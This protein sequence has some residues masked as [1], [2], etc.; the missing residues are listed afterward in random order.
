MFQRPQLLIAWPGKREQ[1]YRFL[2][3]A[4]GMC[5][6]RRESEQVTSAEFM[7]L[8]E[9]AKLDSAAQHVNRTCAV[10]MVFVEMRAGAEGH[11][12]DAKVRIFEQQLRPHSRAGRFLLLQARD[13]AIEIEVL[14]DCRHVAV[15]V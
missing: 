11:Q 1:K 6:G 13:F 5:S 10:S 9:H 2:R 7:S 8:L 4:D 3:S 12:H 14:N 15:F